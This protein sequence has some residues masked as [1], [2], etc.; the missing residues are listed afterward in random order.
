MFH[1]SIA[2]T[3][4]LGTSAHEINS[5]LGLTGKESKERIPSH[6]TKRVCLL[7]CVLCFCDAVVSF[8]EVNVLFLSALY[9]LPRV[10]AVLQHLARLEGASK[11]ICPCEE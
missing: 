6:G 10:T 5:G 2:Q 3:W 11:I 1:A 9:S 8:A 4:L 7:Y